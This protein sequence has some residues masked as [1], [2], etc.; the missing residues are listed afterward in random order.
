MAEVTLGSATLIGGFPLEALFDTVEGTV[1]LW[2]PM[3]ALAFTL[4]DDGV[5]ELAELL[6]RAL[7]PGQVT[8]LC[9]GGCGCRLGTEDADARECGC[10]GGCCGEDEQEVSGR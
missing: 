6:A 10:D 1:M 5:K 7:T 4:S 9:P 3:S 8:P 2:E